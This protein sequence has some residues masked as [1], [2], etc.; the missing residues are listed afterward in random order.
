VSRR[1]YIGALTSL[2][3]VGIVSIVKFDNISTVCSPQQFMLFVHG[4]EVC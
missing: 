3:L 2:V 4:L 1:L